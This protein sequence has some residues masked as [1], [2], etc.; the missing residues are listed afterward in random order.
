V[1]LTEDGAKALEEAENGVPRL[2]DRAFSALSSAER[3]TLTRLVGKILQAGR[4][5]C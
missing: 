4:A 1:T 3:K 5:G 2:L